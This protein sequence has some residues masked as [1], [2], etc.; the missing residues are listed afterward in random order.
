MLHAPST[1][2]KKRSRGLR[3]VENRIKSIKNSPLHKVIYVDSVGWSQEKVDPRCMTFV[4][5]HML[6]NGE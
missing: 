2:E 6:L 3:N 5:L 1:K 4:Y